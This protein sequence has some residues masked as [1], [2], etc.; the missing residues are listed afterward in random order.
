MLKSGKILRFLFRYSLRNNSCYSNKA[1]P[2]QLPASKS[3]VKPQRGDF[4][5]EAPRL[6]N[7]FVG[8]ASLKSYLTRLLPEEVFGIVGP[9]LLKFGSRVGSDIY[10][11][12]RECELN[13]P[14]FSK[15][16]AWGNKKDE[17]VTCNAWKKLK[18][19]SAEE[20]LVAIGYERKH[21]EFS[22]L[23]QI[24][25]LYLFSPSSG[26]F[27]CPLAMTDGAA[28]VLETIAGP[29]FRDTYNRLTT[30]NPEIFWTS[31]QWMTERAGGSDVGSGSDTY[32]EKIM[33]DLYAL[34][35]YKWFTS[36]TDSDI[37]LTLAR[38]V[39]SDGNYTSGSPGLSLFYLETRH[40]DGTLNNI[41]VQRLKD[42]LGTKQLP[43]A[44]LLLHGTNARLIGKPGR[45]VA[46][47]SSM[48]TITRIHNAIAS[49][50]A[51][52]RII[53]LA[54][55]YATRR[56]TFG[57]RLIN[58]PLH[59]K[60]L[61]RMEV[62]T[63]GSFSLL[64]EVARLLGREEA[65][66]ATDSEKL[67]LRILTPLLK[68]YTAK[69]CVPVISE[70]LEAFGGQGY[71]ET[72]GIPGILRDAQVTPIWEG[73]TNILSLDT[74]RAIAKTK[75]EALLALSERLNTAMSNHRNDLKGSANQ[76][77]EVFAKTLE[78]IK[79]EPTLLEPAARDIAMCLSKVTIGALMIEHASWHG[80]S[81]VDIIC[82]QRFCF[83]LKILNI[84]KYLGESQINDGQIVMEGYKKEMVLGHLF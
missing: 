49:V 50:S 84:E 11:F 12:G 4:F 83:D 64:M 27:S 79:N 16:D 35:G 38:E 47:I 51:M 21:G 42:K 75:G 24:A 31:G 61:A 45:G 10:N 40:P 26:L 20:G 17:I 74:L 57:K 62:E 9:D 41:D 19:V 60:T 18:D 37:A 55:D 6:E 52:R 1:L 53:A 33:D 80:A 72:T 73:A 76:V 59:M 67:T 66:C 77:R 32:A 13:P 30:R 70:G 46:N 34:Y 22:R 65:N 29:E 58:H 25:K 15:F 43:T 3:Y 68:L 48:L 81:A 39:D 44:E 54:R 7:Y 8:D 56:V 36:A 2:N 23:H 82:A 78:F 69:M 28:R 5:Q 63:R 71:I 14:T